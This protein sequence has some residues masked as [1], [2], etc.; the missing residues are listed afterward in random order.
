M[1]LGRQDIL[2]FQV[3]IW[4]SSIIHIFDDFKLI[5]K[6]HEGVGFVSDMGEAVRG[7]KK[8]DRV[9]VGWTR[10]SCGLCRHCTS[11]IISL[12]FEKEI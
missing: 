11:M 2:L 1:N 9:G 3:Q 8:G 5:L 10:D 4:N 12:F 6:G 7:F